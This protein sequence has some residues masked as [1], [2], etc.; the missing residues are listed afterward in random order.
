MDFELSE[1]QTL[2]RDSVE[3]CLADSYGFEARRAIVR[4]G[5]F[6]AAAWRRFADMGWLGVALPDALG[7]LDGSAEDLALL[8]EG[9]GRALVLEPV[10]AVATLTAQTLRHADAARARE[11]LPALVAGERMLVLAHHEAGAAGRIDAVQC[12]AEPG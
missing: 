7:G 2:L 10:A 3:R 4:N 5:G 9:L 8:H 6:D 12:R 1:D 11:W